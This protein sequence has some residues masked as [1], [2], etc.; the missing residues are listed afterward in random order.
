MLDDHET[1][2]LP[3]IDI[4][5][6]WALNV[7][8]AFDV[9]APGFAGGYLR[10]SPRRRQ[11]IHAALAQMPSI[12]KTAE[13]PIPGGAIDPIDP[14][15]VWALL[16]GR[17]RSVIDRYYGECPA[18]F[19]R[20]LGKLGAGAH[21]P[22]FYRRL[23]S[24][25]DGTDCADTAR[26]LAHLDRIDDDR[27][28]VAKLLPPQ[29][30]LPGVIAKLDNPDHARKF[31]RSLHLIRQWCSDATD[32]AIDD[33]IRRIG[34]DGSPAKFIA[35]WVRRST[36]GSGPLS[37][38]DAL[39][40]IRHAPDLERTGVRFRNCLKD[41]IGDILARTS[42]FYVTVS[43]SKPVI[44]H[45]QRD[46]ADAPWVLEDFYIRNNR[47]LPEEL[48]EQAEQVLRNHGF[49]PHQR[50][51]RTRSEIETIKAYLWD[52]EWERRAA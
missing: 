42:V 10:A 40:Q 39:R 50:Y 20:A 38:S 14:A 28:T 31:L 1:L 35:G 45:L 13:R 11:V 51:A 47:P 27:L 8:T 23:F 34:R 25:F 2:K 44:I 52:A 9:V 32:A 49:D 26:A 33:G 18:G 6:G 46:Q 5:N 43:L 16:T 3:D 41:Q 17:E 15:E 37:D 7:A 29:W 22:N 12:S 21:W 36:F 30:C 4:N 48:R 24:V 19:L